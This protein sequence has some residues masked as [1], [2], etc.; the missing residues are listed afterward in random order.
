MKKNKTKKQSLKVV[1][2]YECKQNHRLCPI[3]IEE[4]IKEYEN[5]CMPEYRI[6]NLTVKEIK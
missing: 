6:R 4:A 1:I 2:G 3:C 5:K